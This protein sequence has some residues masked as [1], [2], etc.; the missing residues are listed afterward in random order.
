MNR[1]DKVILDFRNKDVD[2]DIIKGTFNNTYILTIR[3]ESDDK[4][5]KWL[6][7]KLNKKQLDSISLK[8]STFVNG[9]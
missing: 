1:G 2:F 3:S 7:I 6:A 8:L 5:F 4:D 9:V